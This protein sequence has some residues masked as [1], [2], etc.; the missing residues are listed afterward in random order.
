MNEEHWVV[1]RMREVYPLMLSHL[2]MKVKAQQIS[3]V[4][5]MKGSYKKYMSMRLN[6]K[7][8]CLEADS[9]G[10]TLEELRIRKKERAKRQQQFIRYWE[11][12]VKKENISW[13]KRVWKF[14]GWLLYHNLM[15][16]K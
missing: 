16:R 11:K 14:A 10:I 12:V 9:L 4:T 13:I 1:Y 6:W 15:W 3:G 2:E 7:L 8:A 5:L